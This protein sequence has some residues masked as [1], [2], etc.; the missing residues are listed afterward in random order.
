M[1]FYKILLATACVTAFA[2]SAHAQ[3]NG[4]VNPGDSS[5]PATAASYRNAM[6]LAS[7]ADPVR[8]AQADSADFAEALR[9]YQ[10]Q[11]WSAAYGRFVTLADR[12]HADS[13]RIA[14][15]MLLYGR[16]LY[17]TEWSAA[18]SQIEQWERAVDAPSTFEAVRRAALTD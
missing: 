17:Q 4:S 5:V 11:R 1:K 13:A 2:A 10:A 3:G 14:M 18:P 7:D 12:G 9:L 6:D 16:E 8:R 15:L